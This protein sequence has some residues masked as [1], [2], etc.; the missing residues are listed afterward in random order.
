MMP[1]SA[2]SVNT[3]DGSKASSGAITPRPANLAMGDHL[4]AD[5]HGDAHTACIS[6]QLFPSFDRAV[7]GRMGMGEDMPVL[8]TPHDCR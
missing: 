4:G 5:T 7:R 8:F 1:R 3:A 6:T 2:S